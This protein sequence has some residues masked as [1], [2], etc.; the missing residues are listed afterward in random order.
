[1]A[2][3]VVI[4]P[5]F[6][7]SYWGLEHALPLFGKRA[8]LPVACLPLLSALTPEDHQVTL[9][10]ENVTPLDFDRISRA[11]IVG[12]TGMSVQRFRMREILEELKTRKVFTAVGGP[13]V[14]VSEDYFGELADVIFVGEA[15]ETWPQFLNDWSQGKHDSRYEQSTMTDMTT[16]PCPRYD[17]LESQHY[18]FGSL[19]I[20]R[21]CP[22][23]CEFCD[24]I[25]TFGRRPRQKTI[26]QVTAE[27][28]A[29]RRTKLQTAFI[30]DDNLIGN[31]RAITPI[32]EHIVRW[33]KENGYP[34]TFFT[35]ASLDLADDPEMMELLVEANIQVVFI[36]VETPNEESLRETKKVHNLRPGGSIADKVKKIQRAGMEVWA[37]MIVG[38]DHDDESI[39]DSQYE[40]LREA[41][42]T[43]AML[44]M[45]FA[46]PKTPLHARL[47]AEERLD[48][49]DRPEYGTNVIPAR[50]TREALRDGY[51]DV[52]QRLNEPAAYFDRVDSLYHDRA[53]PFGAAQRS[54]W[55]KHRLRRALAGGTTLL[56]CAGLFVRLMRKIRDPDQ[57]R[58]YRRRTAAVWRQRHE[59]ESVF[60]YLIKCAMHHHY[61]T[62]IRGMTSDNQPVVNTF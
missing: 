10:D 50:M 5:R 62:L 37:G 31:K 14:T 2:D 21:G 13:W 60:I 45:L 54:Y 30:V 57:R 15:E 19:Q 61:A 33:Q 55:K 46:I 1:M 12:V 58:E 39:F 26:Q 3:I 42:V 28:E 23:Q 40:F 38:F 41:R 32:L 59:P 7:P 11:D 35:Q 44:G 18:M 17:Q 16:V 43:H 8:N 20:S 34:F 22:F 24:I 49:E 52:M 48:L 25:V 47:L 29:L 27:L 6:D 9:L 56:R 4:N 51:I 53:F 36:G